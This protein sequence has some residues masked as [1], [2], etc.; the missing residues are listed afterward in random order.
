MTDRAAVLADMLSSRDRA[1]GSAD[2]IR[3]ITTA[4]LCEMGARPYVSRRA[5]LLDRLSGLAG[6]HPHI[7]ADAVDAH[8]RRKASEAYEALEITI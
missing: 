2:Y 4:V 5:D 8:A 1:E 3:A 7:V 6:E